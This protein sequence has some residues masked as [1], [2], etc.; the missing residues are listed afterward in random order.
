TYH[1]NIDVQTHAV[2]HSLS[3]RDALPILNGPTILR[4]AYGSTLP[5]SNPPRLRCRRVI[6]SSIMAFPRFRRG[7]TSSSPGGRLNG[8]PALDVY[9]SS[10]ACVNAID[11]GLDSLRPT[12]GAHHV[13]IDVDR[14][15]ACGI[16]SLGRMT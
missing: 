8:Y 11:T 4:F 1:L 5:T 15:A 9:D 6:T 13:V 3:L 10:I 14:R 16:R 2:F 12:P 7:S